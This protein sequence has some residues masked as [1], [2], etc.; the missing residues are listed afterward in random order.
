MWYVPL[1]LESLLGEGFFCLDLVFFLAAISCRDSWSDSL[2][3][4]IFFCLARLSQFFLKVKQDL[5]NFTPQIHQK[6]CILCFWFFFVISLWRLNETLPR[7]LISFRSISNVLKSAYLQ[8]THTKTTTHTAFLMRSEVLLGW[9]SSN[10]LL[11]CRSFS[12]NSLGSSGKK[13]LLSVW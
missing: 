2:P 6:R 13:F 10:R 4:L 12:L 8:D 7:K 11:A 5:N 9:F 1:S 3:P